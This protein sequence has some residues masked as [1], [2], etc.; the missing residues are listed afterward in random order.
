[1]VAM[2]IT[3]YTP[4]PS[5][6]YELEELEDHGVS[7]LIETQD[8]NITEKF[9]AAQFGVYIKSVKILPQ[10]LCGEFE[11]T[12]A[13]P[14]KR[15]RGYLATRMK[16]NALSKLI[17]ACIRMKGSMT[18]SVILQAVSV[19]LGFLLV[20]FLVFYAGLSQLGA[21][22]LLIYQAFWILAILI[23]PALRKPM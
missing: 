21:L 6:V 22:E 4:S 19:L 2:F 1:M 12:T 3:S 15:V 16:T 7:F 10:K 8:S 14:E 18:I 9:I 17:T 20:A 11:E 5:M 13:A 23:V